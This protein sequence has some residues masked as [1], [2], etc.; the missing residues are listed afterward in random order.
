LEPG[1]A[2]VTVSCNKDPASA[3]RVI[4][5]SLALEAD[6]SPLQAGQKR[7]LTVRISGSQE[8]VMLEARNLAPAVAELAGGN[9][10][11]A[12]SSGGPE[13]LAQ[14]PLTGKQHGNIL[15]S[16]RLLP[17]AVRSKQ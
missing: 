3:T 1:L 9:P 12:I 7:T 15:V 4:L 13:N 8:R 2:D 11:R 14:F 5:L 10:A 16:I 6:N 17:G